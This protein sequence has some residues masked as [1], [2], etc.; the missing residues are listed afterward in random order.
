M[1]WGAPT[2]CSRCNSAGSS[3]P[4]AICELFS[5]D[6]LRSWR[7]LEQGWPY[8]LPIPYIQGMKNVSWDHTN[9]LKICSTRPTATPSDATP[10]AG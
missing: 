5:F 2:P 3:A 4:D 1:R 7:W 10:S 6:L 9:H 8:S